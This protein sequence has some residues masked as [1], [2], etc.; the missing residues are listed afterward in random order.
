[1]AVE[2]VHL[3]ATAFMAGV[4]V[5]V[6]FV[7][8]PLMAHIG[9]SGYVEYQSRHGVLTSG[10]VGIPMLA[11]ALAAVWLVATRVE[12]REVAI[13]GF[14]LLVMIWASTALLQ[15]PAH[16]ALRRGFDTQAHRWLV[17]TNWIRT[18]AWVAR[19]PLAASLVLSSGTA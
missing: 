6:Q 19:I 18:L 4:I 12:G 8:Y 3:V 14:G 5:F 9:A 15:V 7:H 16:S 2:L 1:M 11:E 13:I 10:V 17:A